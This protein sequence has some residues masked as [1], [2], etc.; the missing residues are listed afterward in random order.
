M[1]TSRTTIR[2][3][4][5]PENAPVVW[6]FPEYVFFTNFVNKQLAFFIFS[7]P[8][9]ISKFQMPNNNIDIRLKQ[10][11]DQHFF[12][13]IKRGPICFSEPRLYHLLIV[14]SPILFIRPG[15]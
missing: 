6:L 14:I 2:I 5:T 4:T 13:I 9:S 10:L 3:M 1:P 12:M 15:K 11:K 7:C 8:Y